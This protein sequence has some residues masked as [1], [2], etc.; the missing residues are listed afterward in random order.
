MPSSYMHVMEY[1]SA[2]KKKKMELLSQATTWMNLEGTML[3]EMCQPQKDNNYRIS[4]MCVQNSLIL[5]E[6]EEERWLPGAGEGV[7]GSGCPMTKL[8]LLCWQL[9]CRLACGGNGSYFRLWRRHTPL[10]TTSNKI[11][12]PA[13]SE[14]EGKCE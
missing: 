11:V 3:S 14:G 4:F 5:V 1:Y 13:S 10:R 2:F 9:P 6:T 12:A 7:K 8:L